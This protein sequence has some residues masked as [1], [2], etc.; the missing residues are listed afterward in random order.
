MADIGYCGCDLSDFRGVDS[1]VGD[2]LKP[3][4]NR[5]PIAGAPLDAVP[6]LSFC[7]LSKLKP[8]NSVSHSKGA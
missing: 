2:D 1:L 5:L 6:H 4:R 3:C 8:R 7:A